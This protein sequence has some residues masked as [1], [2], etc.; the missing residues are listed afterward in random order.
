MNTRE[1]AVKAPTNPNVI[2]VELWS[3][4]LSHLFLD[5]PIIGTA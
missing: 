4:S 2:P 1:A 5:N 3:R